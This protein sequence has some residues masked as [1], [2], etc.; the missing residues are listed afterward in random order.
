MNTSVPR[1]GYLLAGNVLDKSPD[2]FWFYPYDN[3]LVPYLPVYLGA[4]THSYIV[5]LLNI[6]RSPPATARPRSHALLL[7]MLLL[8]SDI[9]DLDPDPEPDNA[10]RSAGAKRG[11]AGG[12]R[13]L[14]CWWLLVETQ[15]I[16]YNL[17]TWLLS[18]SPRRFTPQ[19]R[20]KL[21]SSIDSET[22]RSPP[23]CRP[24][25]VRG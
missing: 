17:S 11:P 5:T 21:Y 8:I 22:N 19:F 24:R 14:H 13:M 10:A 7:V 4:T 1:L 15:Q 12:G 6:P 25:L 2:I 16:C 3:P 23:R 18:S 20:T 9:T